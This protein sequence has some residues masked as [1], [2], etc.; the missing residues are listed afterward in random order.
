M[1]WSDAAARLWSLTAP[2]AILVTRRKLC[3]SMTPR[4][5]SLPFLETITCWT[6]GRCTVMVTGPEASRSFSSISFPL[7]GRSPLNAIK[8]SYCRIRFSGAHWLFQSPTRLPACTAFTM[9]TFPAAEMSTPKLVPGDRTTSTLKVKHSSLAGRAPIVSSCATEDERAGSTS[10]DVTSLAGG[11]SL[12]SAEESTQQMN[13]LAGANREREKRR[14]SKLV[15]RHV[16]L[17]A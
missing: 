10:S 3:P 16:R 4:P 11:S 1:T 5:S 14:P 6:T 7:E 13:I 8:R 15:K 2:S 12:S 17:N 9:Q